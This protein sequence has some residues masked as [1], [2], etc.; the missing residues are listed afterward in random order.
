MT[1]N[2]AGSL[3]LD[4][5]M[6]IGKRS[7]VQPIILVVESVTI[8]RV[9]VLRTHIMLTNTADSRPILFHSWIGWRFVVA[10]AIMIVVLCVARFHSIRRSVFN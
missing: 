7:L 3:P 9:C 5:R 1:T 2:T 4:F 10:V 6:G 8:F